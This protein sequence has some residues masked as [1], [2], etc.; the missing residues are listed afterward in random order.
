MSSQHWPTGRFIAMNLENNGELSLFRA[1]LEDRVSTRTPIVS[2]TMTAS[3]NLTHELRWWASQQIERGN[4]LHA[5]LV[6]WNLQD[7]ND[8]MDDLND[9]TT[10]EKLGEA[11][12]R[13]RDAEDEF[14]TLGVQTGRRSLPHALEDLLEAAQEVLNREPE[15]VSVQ[16]SCRNLL[17][18]GQ[19]PDGELVPIYGN[20]LDIM[21]HVGEN[22]SVDI[23][24]GIDRDEFIAVMRLDRMA[25]MSPG[26]LP[27]LM[28]EPEKH[29]EIRRN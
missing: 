29:R 25:A 20:A 15:G 5:W 12:R 10:L 22:G 17:E 18:P 21:V 24:D 11:I 28:A 2:I 13:G 16:A 1:I 8:C 3:T 14:S 4:I 26:M 27:E 6:P 9:L 19:T 7:S 23:N